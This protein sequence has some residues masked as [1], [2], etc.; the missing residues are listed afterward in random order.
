MACSGTFC[1]LNSSGTTTC[2]NHRG[3]CPT[4][5]PLSS[6]T[7][8]AVTTGRVRADDI[9]NLRANIRDELARYQ[10]HSTSFGA[11]KLALLRTPI[12]RT[13]LE[14]VEKQVREEVRTEEKQ[15]FL[16]IMNVL[17]DKWDKVE[18]QD[19]DQSG[20]K[21]KVYKGIRNNT[22]DWI[23]EIAEKRGITL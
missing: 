18:S 2:S 22:R 15:L 10:L 20:E 11:E 23:K 16:L 4:N 17:T 6:S 7:E 14:S 5:R 19:P 21:W 8:F 3:G 13:S 9:E 12:L 1:N